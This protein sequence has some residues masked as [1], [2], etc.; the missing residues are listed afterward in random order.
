METILDI[1]PIQWGMFQ[2]VYS[3]PNMILPL[4]GG[5]M[6]DQLG[7]RSGLLLFTVILTLGQFVF[8]LGGAKES[9]WL[10]LL[11]RVIFGIGGESMNVAQSAIVTVWFKGKE[12]AFA[13]GVNLSISR[14]GSVINANV[15]P[16]VCEEHGLGMALFVGFLIC[17]FSLFNAIG[18]VLIDAKAEKQNP[19]EKATVS[20]EDKFKMSDLT[21]FNLSFWILTGSCI[22]TYISVFQ[23][24]INATDML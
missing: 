21:K 1:T 23:Y 24:V 4:I 14:V 18:L 15:T 3:V 17:V 20:D 13:L 22:I 5:V 7:I 16:T 8:Y 11:G 9:Y 2:T 6:L 19:E 10:M 12:L